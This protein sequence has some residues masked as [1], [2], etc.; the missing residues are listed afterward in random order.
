MMLWMMPLLF[1]FMALSF[2]SGLSLYWVA[3][4]VF[5]IVLQY[6]V[7]GWGGLR[8]TAAAGG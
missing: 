2:P 5:R 8:Q 1:T 6:R 3:S 7:T 4:S